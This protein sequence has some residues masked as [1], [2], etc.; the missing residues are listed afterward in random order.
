MRCS[1]IVTTVG[2]PFLAEQL[3]AIAGQTRPAEQVVLVNNG[4]P[5]VVDRVVAEHRD[6]LPGLLL[7]EDRTV[8]SCGYARNVG[9]AAS[10][11]P[12]LLFVDDD[13]VVSA[14]YVNAMSR[15]LDDAEMVAARVDLDRLNPPELLESWR[16]TQET[17]PMTYHD[18]LPWVIGGAFGIRRDAF[19]RIQGYD[20]NLRV[21]EDTDLCWRVQ[22]AGGPPPVF[23]A[24]APLSYRIRRT[25]RAAFRQGRSWGRW[26][27]AL[28]Q[29][30]QDKG[31]PER[32]GQVRVL[33]RWLRPIISVA[34][35]PGR[36]GLTLAARQLGDRVGRLE[37]SLRQRR[38]FL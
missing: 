3:Q 33:G 15:A 16:G 7:V 24:E 29:R 37:G 11:E 38:L 28:Y 32:P 4:A 19:E 22:L 5:G 12:G 35:R 13:D 2:G 9:A 23:Q 8:S 14:G 27:V 6:R 21:C 31:Y 1:L 18:F 26:E 25:P 36:V 34:R 10:V 17:G 30:Y 20:V